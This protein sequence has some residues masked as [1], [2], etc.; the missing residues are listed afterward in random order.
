[1][2]NFIIISIQD[3]QYTSQFWEH[4]TTSSDM[5]YCVSIIPLKSKFATIIDVKYYQIIYKND[6]FIGSYK[7]K[8]KF[9]RQDHFYYV[10]KII[11]AFELHYLFSRNVTTNC[12]K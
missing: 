10:V 12:I 4:L 8:N 1:M 3:D 6:I 11:L 7:V 5:F 9:L 2:Q